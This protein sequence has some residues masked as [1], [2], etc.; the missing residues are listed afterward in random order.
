V[1]QNHTSMHHIDQLTGRLGARTTR[2]PGQRPDQMPATPAPAT[3]H[4]ATAP[5][6]TR[7]DHLTN[8]FLLLSALPTRWNV[9]AS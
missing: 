8:D 1:L 2:T 7:P 6:A 4:W 5:Q 9:Q 3:A